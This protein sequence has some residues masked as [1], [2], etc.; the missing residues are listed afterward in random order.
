MKLITTLL[1][2][3]T[4]AVANQKAHFIQKVIDRKSGIVLLT[5]LVSQSFI[6]QQIDGA[7]VPNSVLLRCEVEVVTLTVDDKG[8]PIHETQLAC[9]EGRRFR[10]I[11]VRLNERGN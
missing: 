10:L 3:S 5:P 8:N 9:G 2:L 1:L 11:S 7:E 4:F 6:A